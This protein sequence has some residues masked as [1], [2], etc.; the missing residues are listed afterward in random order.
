MAIST[1]QVVEGARQP[2]WR[3]R[4]WLFG[5]VVVPYG[6]L[7]LIPTG[8]SVMAAYHKVFNSPPQV[9]RGYM[10]FAAT[11]TLAGIVLAKYIDCLVW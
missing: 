9:S 5:L 2:I 4:P 10:F 7:S 8:F 11:G 6:L 3:R 1:E